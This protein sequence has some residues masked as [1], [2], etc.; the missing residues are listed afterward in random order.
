MDFGEGI[1]P[2]VQDKMYKRYFA[3]KTIS[4]EEYE[5]LLLINRRAADAAL[6]CDEYRY[7][8]SRY[9]V[10]YNAALQDILDILEGRNV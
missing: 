7:E 6:K 3:T 10:G 1:S 9:D 4:L 2:D 5:T 8:D